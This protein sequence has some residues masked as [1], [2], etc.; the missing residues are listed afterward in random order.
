MTSIVVIL[1]VLHREAK[2]LGAILVRGGGQQALGL[3][4]RLARCGASGPNY[5]RH[6]RCGRGCSHRQ[7]E[8]RGTKQAVA[9]TVVAV[10]LGKDAGELSL[11]IVVL[12]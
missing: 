5:G 1:I 11:T 9:R 6:D 4:A 7:T 2:Q 12:S 10:A 8:R 3:D